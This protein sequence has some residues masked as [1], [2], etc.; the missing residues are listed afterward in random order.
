MNDKI[1]S[2]DNRITQYTAKDAMQLVVE[3]MKTESIHVI[4]VITLDTLKNFEMQE[5]WDEQKNT[6]DIV[7]ADNKAILDVAGVEDEKLI[8]EAE[9]SLFIKMFLHFLHKNSAKV[10][11]LTENQDTLDEVREYVNSEYSRIHIVETATW[12]EHGVSDDMIL[13]RVNGVEAD[14]ILVSLPSPIQEEFIIRNRALLNTKI[15][16]GMGTD[17]Q[18]RNNKKGIHKMYDLLTCKMLKR[19]IKKARQ[20][21]GEN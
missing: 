20:Q 15:W 4:E 14:C 3:Y 9:S 16:F 6:F 18:A 5:G 8:K 7:L 10:F 12:E 19:E 21:D 1:Q 17:F 2:L 11:L 13:N